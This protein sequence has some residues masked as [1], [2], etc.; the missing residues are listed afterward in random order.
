[1]VAGAGAGLVAGTTTV[2]NAWLRAGYGA[3]GGVA[4]LAGAVITYQVSKRR[5]GREAARRVRGEVLSDVVT[6][7]LPGD[8]SVLGLLLATNAVAPFRG[9]QADLGWLQKWCDDPAACP[10]VVLTGPAGVGKGRLAVQFA[11]QRPEPWV[12]GWLVA[13]RG[14]DAVAAVRACGD[15]ALI[16]VDDADDR[17]D[18]AD[19]IASLV[20]ARS[21][22][23]VPS[24]CSVAWVMAP[25]WGL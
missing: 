3:A 13:G 24:A 21:P 22:T 6:E 11:M 25:A 9:R 20:A 8:T 15:P 5:E 23:R 7:R 18:L 2:T 12:T 1:M 10:V 17:G 4:G 16:L 19:L 14:G